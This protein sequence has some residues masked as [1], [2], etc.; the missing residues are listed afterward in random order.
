[1]FAFPN[2]YQPASLPMLFMGTGTLW[3][4]GVLPLCA[5][6]LLYAVVMATKKCECGMIIKGIQLNCTALTTGS[7]TYQCSRT[8]YRLKGEIFRKLLYAPPPPPA[9]Y[10]GGGWVCQSKSWGGGGVGAI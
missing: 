2:S 4:M 5:D 9:G 8:M 1:M 3:H 10:P 6:L 7:V